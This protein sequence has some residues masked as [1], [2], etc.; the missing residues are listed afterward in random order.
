MDAAVG[1]RRTGPGQD[2]RRRGLGD[3]VGGLL[4]AVDR[5]RARAGLDDASEVGELPRAETGLLGTLTR[6]LGASAE[7]PSALEPLLRAPAVRLP[8]AWA[9]TVS[10]HAGA[11]MALLEDPVGVP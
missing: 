9:L 2:P 10:T 5:A 1:P 7:A 3:R 4:A 8:L 11:P 6:L